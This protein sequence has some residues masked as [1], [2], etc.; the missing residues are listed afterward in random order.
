MSKPRL[1]VVNARLLT[2]ELNSIRFL[3]GLERAIEITKE[4]GLETFFDIDKEVFND[5]IIYPDFIN[6]GTPTEA[7]VSASKE[8]AEGK[9]KHARKAAGK[10]EL[11]DKI[12][13]EDFMCFCI[14]NHLYF[15]LYPEA[16]KK[17]K[18]VDPVN[19]TY[20][21]FN[22]HTHPNGRLLAS[23]GEK[24]G[25][26]NAA[27]T[28]KRNSSLRLKLCV[29]PI[30]IIAGVHKDLDK[31]YPLLLYQERPSIPISKKDYKKAQVELHDFADPRI[32]LVKEILSGSRE[33][34]VTEIY[35]KGLLYFYPSRLGG[36]RV[37]LGPGFQF[38]DFS[39]I[40]REDY[41][42]KTLLVYKSKKQWATH[43]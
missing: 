38:K 20:A 32:R 7:S 31:P 14:A 22:F 21:L 26:V 4:T 37:E 6:I 43:T 25:D 27:N 35:N 12:D 36:R 10:G 11:D 28:M 30:S 39:Y 2:R 3:A 15:E 9:F 24:N 18:D 17:D 16:G 8:Y 33:I 19:R 40:V 42:Y 1:E 34:P 41:S 5:N 23:M 13:V 29:K